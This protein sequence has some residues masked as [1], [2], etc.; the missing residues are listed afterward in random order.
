MIAVT[1]SRLRGTKTIRSCGN[2]PEK[3]MRDGQTRKISTSERANSPEAYLQ[4]NRV[5]LVVV[6]GPSSGSE[7]ALDAPKVVLG[8]GPGVDLEFRDEAMSREHLAFE[9]SEGGFRV[10]DL[11]S[12]NGVRVNGADA[13]AVDLEHGDTIE[14]GKHRFQYLVEEQSK[15]GKAH[16]IQDH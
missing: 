7:Y 4:K 10:R 15:S 2:N 12:T 6:N 13:L 1:R 11:A 8:R 9:L 14:V 5:S 16:V 3:M